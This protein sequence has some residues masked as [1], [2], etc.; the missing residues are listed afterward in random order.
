MRPAGEPVRERREPRLG[1]DDETGWLGR[2]EL[3]NDEET[4]Q[5]EALPDDGQSTAPRPFGRGE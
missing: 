5:D 2:R 1:L 3:R 4:G